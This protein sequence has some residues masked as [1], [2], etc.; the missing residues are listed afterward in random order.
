MVAASD[1]DVV[2]ADADGVGYRVRRCGYLGDQQSSGCGVS[3][4]PRALGRD[5]VAWLVAPSLPKS[6]GGCAAR[7]SLFGASL[8]SGDEWFVGGGAAS[9]GGG[10]FF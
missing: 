7:Q 8:G 2:D 10:A 6:T 4:K 5:L 9:C 3:S 1:G